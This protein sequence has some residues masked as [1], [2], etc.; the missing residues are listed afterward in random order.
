MR[1]Q[2]A[3][4][5]VILSYRVYRKGSNS[6]VG[7]TETTKML[8]D[9][10]DEAFHQIRESIVQNGGKIEEESEISAS[11]WKGKEFGFLQGYVYRRMRVFI[12]GARIFEIQSD[13]TNW[14]ILSDK[15]K[16]D[17]RKE[18]NRFFESFKIL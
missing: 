18:T 1:R 15:V 6:I 5:A 7:I 2:S 12:V 11:G 16:E 3:G 9:R 17:W 8:G 14:H 10:S 4:D 13:V